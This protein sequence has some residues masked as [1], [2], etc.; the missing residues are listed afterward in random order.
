MKNGQDV[1][2]EPIMLDIPGAIVR[3]YRPVLDE[4]ERARRMK[5]I[6]DA[7]AVL[8]QDVRKSNQRATKR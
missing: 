3:V 6:H 4:D 1:Y 2:Q 8:L 5:R 7:A